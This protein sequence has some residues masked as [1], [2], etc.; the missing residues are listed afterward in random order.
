MP[1]NRP[2]SREFMQA[3]D[4]VHS[5]TDFEKVLPIKAPIEFAMSHS[6]TRFDVYQY[7]RSKTYIERVSLKFSCQ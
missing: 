2:P 7:P 4:L 3:L 6:T 5:R 1:I